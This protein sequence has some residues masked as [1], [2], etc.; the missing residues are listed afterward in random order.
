MEEF[1]RHE[2]LLVASALNNVKHE[3]WQRAI[4]NWD[5]EEIKREAFMMRD[6][7]EGLA[8]KAYRMREATK[9]VETV[10]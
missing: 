2:L 3:W 8:E 4:D 1:D 6:F 7:Y 10:R 5:N 9:Q